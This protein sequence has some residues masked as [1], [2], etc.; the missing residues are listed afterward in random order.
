MRVLPKESLVYHS[1]H[2]NL[3][4]KFLSSIRK[5]VNEDRLK[6][7]SDIS[8]DILL[9]KIFG[10]FESDALYLK[11]VDLF[12]K[13]TEETRNRC[14]FFLK[15]ILPNLKS[16]DK[17]LDV[18][19]GN[20]R[21]TRLIGRYFQET[22][23]ID[24][25]PEVLDN[26]QPRSFPKSA[27]LKKIYQSFLHAIL[28]NEYFDLIVLSHVM[29]HFPETKW[30]NILQKALSSLKS[31]G[32]L[33]V[34]VNSGLDRETLGHHFNGTASTIENFIHHINQ[35]NK[36]VDIYSS[37]ESF[38]AKDLTTMLHICGLH[39]HDRNGKAS[40]DDLEL[41]INNNYLLSDKRYK[42]EVHQHF[43]VITNESAAYN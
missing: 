13:S 38:R 34:V 5:E 32:K 4:E 43:I 9:P 22:T 17:L 42:M 19:P 21:L 31:S 11:T 6:Y 40:K 1:A 25:V 8:K 33:V 26:I 20:G 16:Y 18:G 35:L 15:K 39:L 7:L 14:T 30:M 24:T 36:K 12:I 10:K 41:Y 29:Y 3:D 23:L 2:Y 37:K 27:T 28:P